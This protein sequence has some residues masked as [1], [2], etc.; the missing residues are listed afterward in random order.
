MIIF[1]TIKF[2]NLL[3]YGDSLT[4][5]QLD[6]AS[7]TIIRGKN[8]SGKSTVLD[9]ICYG[10]FGKP[11]RKS[12]KPELKNYR[13]NKGLYV[14]VEFSINDDVYIVK[15]GISPN[16]FDVYKNGD[17]KN[18][19][20][21]TR[22]YQEVFER[23][24]LKFNY[25]SFTQIVILGKATYVSFLR[26]TTD[27]RRKFIESV[28]GLKLF[29]T[30]SENHKQ[31]VSEFKSELSEF[32]LKMSSNKEKIRLLRDH[33]S[34][35]DKMDSKKNDDL[36]KKIEELN[37]EVLACKERLNNL[38]QVDDISSMRK[39]IQTIDGLLSKAQY[40][41]S[42][43]EKEVR[44]YEDNDVCSSCGQ[45]IQ[46][47]F[48]L[49]TVGRLKSEITDI[50]GAINQLNNKRDAL[51]KKLTENTDV[52]QKRQSINN[53]IHFKQTVLEEHKKSLQ[54]SDNY[55]DVSKFT[56]ELDEC[57]QKEKD[58]STTEA[59]LLEKAKMFSVVT[60][61]L[62][63]N[64]IK[65]IIIKRYIPLVIK[66]MNNNLSKLGFFVRFEMDDDFNESI[67]ARGVN[68]IGYNTYSEGEKLRIDFAMLLTWREISK[69][70]NNLSTNL[71]ILDEVLD[72]S[73]DEA[74]VGAVLLLLQT[75]ERQNVFVISHSPDKWDDFF[76]RK[77]VVHRNAN[78][79]ST[80]AE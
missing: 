16:I 55:Y 77:L 47:D 28:L 51:D 30:M 20:S 8:G 6:S 80:I 49:S 35:V 3:S 18:Q 4:T 36:E 56:N 63:D 17:L 1:K 58:L 34:N 15:R 43:K 69:I 5:I 11:F 25:N 24:I 59:E 10:L 57:L 74:G 2:K 27:Q 40:K 52:Q 38:P 64:G 21:H 7:S 71:L 39:K 26:L 65:R 66:I 29:A 70:R 54:E 62:K 9:A 67:L 22:D 72:A 48:K 33:L 53:E 60:N 12:N 50:R 61:M 41:L 37:A 13:N 46:E 68:E 75:L 32:K 19:E 44:F 23:E 76:D 14:E 31:N 45:D 78:G 73:L 42:L 79:F